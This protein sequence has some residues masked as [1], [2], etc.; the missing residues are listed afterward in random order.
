MEFSVILVVDVEFL[1]IQPVAV[2]EFIVEMVRE[3]VDESDD[4]ALSVVE[5]S[6]CA[7]GSMVGRFVVVP[8][9]TGHVVRLLGFCDGIVSADAPQERITSPEGFV[10]LKLKQ[11]C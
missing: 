9:S 8:P 2:A 4:I 10:P 3:S 6:I 5:S 7:L 11:L 1:V